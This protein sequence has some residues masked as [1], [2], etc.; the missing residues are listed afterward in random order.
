M[1]DGATRGRCTERVCPEI[2]KL[3]VN[4]PTPVLETLTRLLLPGCIPVQCNRTT[5]CFQ[6]L[7]ES[8]ATCAHVPGPEAAWNHA[9]LNSPH[10]LLLEQTLCCLVSSTVHGCPSPAHPSKGLTLFKR[11]KS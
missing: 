6:A 1:L 4:P 2:D 8:E 5:W 10:A 7:Q 3:N 11:K 9:Y